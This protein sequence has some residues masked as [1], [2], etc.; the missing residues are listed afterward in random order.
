MVEHEKR[1]LN[2]V[3]QFAKKLPRFE[4]GRIDYRSSDTAPVTTIYVRSNGE[5]L[6]LK[7]SDRVGA[8]PRKWNSV[9]GFLDH[10]R[11]LRDK[12][13]EE[14]REELQITEDNIHSILYGENYRFTDQGKTWIVFPVLAELKQKPEIILDW[15]H[16][17]YKWIKPEELK[18]F[19]IVPNLD[20]GLEHVLTPGNAT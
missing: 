18:E 14:L 12:V 3:K 13:L 7:R 20:K 1:A 16:T 8:Y 11:P 19:D 9:S 10:V 5:I 4:D 17:E 2:L 6:L 15:E